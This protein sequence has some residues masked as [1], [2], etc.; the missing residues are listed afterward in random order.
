MEGIGRAGA[1]LKKTDILAMFLD[2]MYLFVFPMSYAIH[3]CRPYTFV[4]L[5]RWQFVHQCSRLEFA[6]PCKFREHSKYLC[7]LM[8]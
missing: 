3:P 7:I 8:S 2:R 6:S 5:V 4:S 1:I